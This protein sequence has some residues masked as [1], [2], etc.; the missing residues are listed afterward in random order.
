MRTDAAYQRYFRE[1]LFHQTVQRARRESGQR[2]PISQA[3]AINASILRRMTEGARPSGTTQ[4]EQPG[5]Q[6]KAGQQVP[7]LRIV[8]EEMAASVTGYTAQFRDHTPADSECQRIWRDYLQMSGVAK[9]GA[10][11]SP[12]VPISPYDPLWSQR[13]T[14]RRAGTALSYLHTSTIER[15]YD[16]ALGEIH[17]GPLGDLQLWRINGGKRERTGPA[18]THE[19]AC[20]LSVLMDKMSQREYQQVRDWVIEGGRDPRTGEIDPARF[21]GPAAAARSVAVLEEL[22]RQGI[23]YQ[24]LRDLNPGQIKAKI[25]AT[26]IDIRLTETRENQRFAGARIYDNGIEISYS[27]NYKGTNNRNSSGTRQGGVGSAEN[28]SVG[29]VPTP[30]E[31]VDL[32]RFAQGKP[33]P[34]GDHPQL[35]IGEPATHTE[36]TWDKRARGWRPREYQDS[37]HS[38]R[39]STYVVK[40]YETGG[41]VPDG[42]KVTIRRNAKNRGLGW[43]FS[44]TEKAS[45]Y[46]DEAVRSARENVE[47]ALDV[48]GLIQTWEGF[49]EET[50]AAGTHI[51]QVDPAQWPVPTYSVEPEIAAIQ[52]AY[53]DV[54]TGERESLLRPGAS[55]DDYLASEGDIGTAVYLGT[56]AEKIRDHADDVLEELIGTFDP[57]YREV[58]GEYGS[59]SGSEFVEKRFDPARVAKYMTS[60]AGQWGNMDS[61]AAALRKLEVGPEELLGTGFNNTRMRDRLIRFDPDT[62][63]VL[64]ASHPDAFLARI[65]TVVAAAVN[66]HGAHLTSLQIDDQGVIAWRADKLSRTGTTTT[67]TGE[68]GQVFS[69]GDHGEILTRFISGQNA[70]IVPGYEAR[71]VAPLPGQNQSVEQRTRLRGYEQVLTDHIEYQIGADMV[72]GRSEVGEGASL[73]PL[74]SRLYGTKHPTDYLERATTQPATPDHP[75]PDHSA[76]GQV[77]QAQPGLG[78]TGLDPWIEATVATEARRVRYPNAIREGSTVYAEY[79]ATFEEED[80]ADD[81]HF[82]AWRLTG[83]RNMAVLSG[84]DADGNPAPAGYFDPVMTGGSTNQGLI[85]YLTADA[86]VNDDGTITPGDPDGRAPLM[87]MRELESVRFDPFDR[88]QMTATTL[89]QSAKVT[90]PTG[91]AMM[92]FGGWTADDPIVVSTAFAE[93]NPIRGADGQ[94][95]ALMPG[96]KLSDLHGNK[97][98]VSLIVDPDMDPAEAAARDIASEVAAFAANPEMDVVMSPFSLISRRN[99]GAARELIDQHDAAKADLKDPHGNV[100]TSGAIAPMRF[101][102]THMA[103]DEKTKVYDEEA[104][105]AGR[106]RRASSQL[107]WALGSQGC[108]AVLSEFYGHN[109]AAEARFRELL[110]TVGLDMDATGTLRVIGRRTIDANPHQA[111]QEAAQPAARQA[112]EQADKAAAQD[113]TREPTLGAVSS[114]PDRRVFEMP[115]LVVTSKDTLNTSAMRRGFGELIGDR[116]GYLEIPFPLT[117]PTGEQT[118]LQHIPGTVTGTGTRGAQGPGRVEHLSYRLPIMSSHLRSG[119]DFEDGTSST[120]DYTSR[121]LD[122]FEEACRYRHLRN[123]LDDPQLSASRL[124]ALETDMAKCRAKAQQK[125]TSITNDLA[126]RVFSGK[127]N[128]FKEGLMASRLPDSATAVW[129]SDPRLDIDQVAM[130][131]RMAQ[132]LGL[133]EGDHAL[134]WRDP[135]LRDAGV[136]YLRVAIDER[137]VGIAINPVIDAGFD[138]DFDGDS[139]A[140]VRLHSDAAINEAWERLSTHANLLD[141]GRRDPATGLHPLAMHNSLDTKLGHHYDT[142]AADEFENGFMKEANRVHLTPEP[143]EDVTASALDI[144]EQLSDHYRSVQRSQFGHALSFTDAAAHLDSVRQV[145]VATGAKGSERK[146]GDYARYLGYSHDPTTS[147]PHSS[148]TSIGTG[149]AAVAATVAATVVRTDLA[150]PGITEADQ[151]DSMYSTAVKS[152]GTGVAGMFSQRAVRALR[153]TDLKAVLELTYPVT[154]SI[155]QA[156]HDASEARHKYTALLGSGR[157]LWRGRLMERSEDT[158]RW[159][160]VRDDA[161]EPVQ[162]STEQWKRQVIDFYT[163]PDGFN[164][165]LNP[166]Y[167]DRVATAL[168]DETG[169]MRNLEEDEIPGSSLMDRQAYGGDLSTLIKAAERHENVYDG[170]WN[171]T[172]CSHATRTQRQL[173]KSQGNPDRV[174]SIDDLAR[175]RSLRPAITADVL[176]LDT[177]A[178]YDTSA[179]TRGSNSRSSLAVAVNRRP[180]SESGRALAYGSLTVL[181][182]PTHAPG[183]LSLTRAANERGGDAQP[184]PGDEPTD[185]DP[186]DYEPYDYEPDDEDEY[187]L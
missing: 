166:T 130:G 124:D 168:A 163:S 126:A 39:E 148:P 49:L 179:R 11:K 16:G 68:I 21:M 36:P 141:L 12:V 81:N 114:R 7:Y 61:L 122:L 154:Q 58:E 47:T 131:P 57:V 173:S 50:K 32:V 100:L 43:Y 3:R 65:G 73:N 151:R 44:N 182:E 13:A 86:V 55:I 79:H 93:G 101:I 175:V 5:Q 113:V 121:Y 146:L 29:Y 138:G 95:R 147:A 84:T 170:S 54:L 14:V 90:E 41:Q 83:G 45:E 118:E 69:P 174:T 52:R 160:V 149:T 40:D 26:G 88:Q 172:F 38:G 85:R 139:V 97:G 132:T 177:I 48:E 87:A 94:L 181:T 120:H 115:V 161:G 185:H 62:A 63:V 109:G 111:T 137:L 15:A 59:G 159:K 89:M 9:Q 135:V 67:V 125:F 169:T 34:R 2:I 46:L 165:A 140:V 22:Q 129:T 104:T 82:D 112:A 186:N 76:P 72:S 158:G 142:E 92:T 96:D 162:A 37:Y 176:K 136:R 4:Q 70:L 31:A 98:V 127:R 66:R 91:V 164:V 75:A 28:R 60:E 119:Q 107:A 145:C 19:D 105:Q 155:L 103:V 56:A 183:P 1:Y 23:G 17:S 42:A 102:V 178:D 116:G 180:E 53:W 80:P 143:D 133:R 110:L 51:S 187:E 8:D 153:N 77:G 157:D 134:I 64:D 123:Q 35:M 18:M 108:E 117:Y 27:T 78:A 6:G 71:I 10:W 184:K 171:E 152:F 106:G 30:G 156:K 74:Y 128:I 25:T 33:V 167:V 24:V 150:T 99:A 144:V 20:G